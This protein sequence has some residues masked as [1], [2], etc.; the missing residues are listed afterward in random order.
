MSAG[1]GQLS[2]YI[3]EKKEGFDHNL[4]GPITDTAHACIQ[5]VQRHMSREGTKSK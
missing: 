3:F 1:Q 2:E 4:S 5:K